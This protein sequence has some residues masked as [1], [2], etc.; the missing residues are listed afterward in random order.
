MK[1]EYVVLDTKASENRKRWKESTAAE[2][3]ETQRAS[4][5]IV[6]RGLG[7]SEDDPYHDGS[8]GLGASVVMVIC[9]QTTRTRRYEAYLRRAI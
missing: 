4:A 9:G 6:A 8:G 3:L 1:R 2:S 5:L 7:G